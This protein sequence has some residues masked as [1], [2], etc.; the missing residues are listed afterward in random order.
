MGFILKIVFISCVQLLTFFQGN[1]YLW[2]HQILLEKVH[3]MIFFGFNSIHM[4]M[5]IFNL[6]KVDMAT[7]WYLEKLKKH[8]KQ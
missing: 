6:N 1:S 8:Y 4:I 5:E 7:G 2:A 3:Q